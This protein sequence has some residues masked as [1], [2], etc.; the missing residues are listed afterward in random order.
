MK[1]KKF[2]FQVCLQPERLT[3]TA[4]KIKQIFL[5]TPIVKTA[6]LLENAL[7]LLRALSDK[8]LDII[9]FVLL[10]FKKIKFQVCLKSV[11]LTQT[12]KF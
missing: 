8:T 6:V 4:I 12:A 10:K 1:F 2:K 9:I 7:A 5:A 3:Q 11:G